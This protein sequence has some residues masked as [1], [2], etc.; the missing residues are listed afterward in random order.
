MKRSAWTCLL[1]LSIASSAEAAKPIVV[2]TYENLQDKAL[3]NVP[4]TFS[5]VGAAGDFTKGMCPVINGREV[6]AQVDVLRRAA[7]GSI[8]HALVSLVLPA[9]PAGGKVAV[10]YV[11]KAPAAPGAFKW[12]VD[13]ANFDAK[14]VLT[15]G[16]GKVLTSDV[17]KMLGADWAKSA[18][19][20]VLYDGSI[21]KEYEIRHVPVDA[22]GTAD[23]HLEVYWRLRVFTGASSVRIAAVVENCKMW[24]TP[25]FVFKPF[26]NFKK[27]E[28][29]SG[30][31]TLFSEGPFK[32]LDRTRYRI[33]VWSGGALEDIHRR[34]NYDYWVKGK[35]V[36]LYKWV[37]KGKP[38]RGEQVDSVYTSPKRDRNRNDEKRS[39]GILE[40]G[41]IHK[42]MPGAGG[43]W[44]IGPYPA[45]TVGYLLGGGGAKIYRKILHADGNGGGAF[46][47]HIRQKPG[48]PGYKVH[49]QIRAR[50]GQRNMGPRRV[51]I[52]Q[53][54]HAHAPSLGY[55]SYMITGD[56]YYAE[57]ASFWASYQL[58]E[59]PYKGLDLNAPGRAQAWGLR[60]VV[61]AGFILPDGHPLLGYIT[62]HI[63]LYLDRFTAAHVKSD[64]KIHFIR[65]VVASSGRAYWVNCRYNSPWQH[66]WLV[67]SLGNAA[68]KG[69]A[70]KGRPAANWA[71]EYV[72][73]LYTSTD[74]YTAPDGKVYRFDPRDAMCYSTATRLLNTKVIT[75]PNGT[76]AIKVLGIIRNMSNYGEMWYYTK[77]N[78]D[79]CWTPNA[80]G[81]TTAPDAK[82]NWPVREKGW[83]HGMM[84]DFMKKRQKRWYNMHTY[85]ASALV[86]A[87]EG[88]LPK[89]R[90]AWA[91][92][93]ELSGGMPEGGFGPMILHPR[94][95]GFK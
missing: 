56:K 32:H 20:K 72:V 95:K 81:V 46:Y 28:L 31:K 48:V 30:G 47:I 29:L 37:A 51:T 66:S 34:P 59:Y 55:I 83:G 7:D 77:V 1:V 60:H 39:Q 23:T 9:L 19:V 50:P 69:F 2:N 65:D 40:A 74:E 63:N 44:D 82:G 45:W 3:T 87:V 53:P 10:G 80:G 84:W 17:G 88:G 36:P 89:S 12:A 78:E 68:D 4:V 64:K 41:I 26:L 94:V 49:E 27:V 13:R 14:L 79:N 16:G 35:F 70:K 86:V 43:R 91:K 33:L 8:R 71:A 21:M 62:K 75:K 38:L 22:S 15:A 76:K 6:P 42:H 18:G 57:E 92:M 85:S 73:G 67:W 25:G 54:D 52:V 90:A 58:G 24:R 5:Q 93:V 11:D 61:D